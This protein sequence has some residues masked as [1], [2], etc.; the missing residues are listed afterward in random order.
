VSRTSSERPKRFFGRYRGNLYPRERKTPQAKRQS[1]ASAQAFR[2][3]AK[4]QEK[5]L[6]SLHKAGIGVR[7]RLTNELSRELSVSRRIEPKSAPIPIP[8]KK[9]TVF[10]DYNTDSEDDIDHQALEIERQKAEMQKKQTSVEV[11]GAFK[12]VQSFLDQVSRE[13]NYMRG[14]LSS[15]VLTLISART[16]D[17]GQKALKGRNSFDTLGTSVWRMLDNRHPSLRSQAIFA[18]SFALTGIPCIIA[19]NELLSD[20]KDVI[21]RPRMAV[22]DMFIDLID[23]FLISGRNARDRLCDRDIDIINVYLQRFGVVNRKIRLFFACA[24]KALMFTSFQM[25]KHIRNDA[26]TC[27]RNRRRDALSKTAMNAF[28]VSIEIT[29]FQNRRFKESYYKY[30]YMKTMMKGSPGHC[31][32]GS[33]ADQLHPARR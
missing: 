3:I 12:R 8:L 26:V 22:D 18:I 10:D 32:Y 2:E 4:V 29:K 17:E 30:T 13:R 21:L 23:T 7:K 5:I 33:Y 1:L 25:K 19:E 16:K 14:E 31:P 28:M 15:K 27:L 20:G 6:S 24:M 11:S 9:R